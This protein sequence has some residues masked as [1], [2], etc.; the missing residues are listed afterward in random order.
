MVF[1]LP[2]CHPA[3]LPEERAKQLRL[4]FRIELSLAS[5][6]AIG[7]FKESLQLASQLGA[8][9]HVREGVLHG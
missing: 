7:N 2:D 3:L 8:I 6:R 9:A 1:A 5:G 4:C